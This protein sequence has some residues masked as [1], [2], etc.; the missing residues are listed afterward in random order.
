MAHQSSL[1]L[2]LIHGEPSWSFSSDR[3]EAAVTQKGGHLAPVRFRLGSGEAER[4]VEPYS[5]AP[6]GDEVPDLPPVLQALRGDFFCAPFGG[7][8]TPYKGER[9]PAHGESANAPWQFQALEAQEWATT[10]H[11]SLETT[12]REARI[13]KA[14]TLR[15]GHTALYCR[16]RISG[17]KGK[18]SFGHHAMLRFPDEPESGRIST[19]RL[20]YGQVA[21]LPLEQPEAGGYSSLEP[22]ALFSRLDRVPGKEGKKIDLSRYPA[23]RGFEDLVMTVHWDRHDLAWTAVAFPAH[24]YVWF[25]LKDPRVLQSTVFWISNGGRHYAPWNGRHVNVMG[26]EDVTSWFHYGLAESAKPNDLRRNKLQTVREFDPEKPFDVN[27]I[28][29]VAAIPPEFQR[30]RAIR[31][32]KGGVTLVSSERHRVEIPL[33]LDFLYRAGE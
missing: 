5:I 29:G 19:S 1:P 10:L 25:T 20:Y 28:M 17:M 31:P 15:Q 4:V 7:N 26:I 30:V 12:I 24:G 13:E 8:E 22:G 33:D 21:P 2:H 3:V 27:Y 32:G 18:M 14:I 6:W 16:H 23:R 9:H 11:L